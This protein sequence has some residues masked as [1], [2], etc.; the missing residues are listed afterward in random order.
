MASG[1][2]LSAGVRQNLLSL[3]NTATLSSL[4]QGRLATGKKV[5]S[6]LD[7]PTNF[8]TSQSLQDRAGDL[9]NLLD[10]IGQATQTLQQ[11]SNG[12]S[13][14]TTL[15]QSAK[16]IAKQASQ[17]SASVTNYAAVNNNANVAAA[18][19]LNGDESV[20]SLTGDSGVA[21]G[22]FGAQ[23]I[24]LSF[25]GQAEQLGQASGAAIAAP[26]AGGVAYSFDLT[27]GGVTHTVSYTSLAADAATN[28]VAGLSASIT[29][30][31]GAGPAATVALTNNAGALRLTATNADVDFTI[32]AANANSGLSNGAFNST[33]LLDNVVAGGGTAGASTL[34]ID[35]NGGTG[36]GGTTKTITFGTGAGQISTLADLKNE[37]NV[38]GVGGGASGDVTVGAFAGTPPVNTGTI[39]LGLAAGETNTLK[40]TTS[41][42][43]V[44]TAAGLGAARNIGQTGGIGNTAT[45]LS[46]TFNSAATLADSDPSTL[47]NGGN[48][49]ITV[50]GSAQTVGVSGTDRLS[51]VI[52]KLKANATLNNNLD[53]SVS[54]GNLKIASKTADVDFQVTAGAVAGGVGTAGLGLATTAQNS[55]SLLDLLGSK[56]SGGP[57]AAQGSTLTLAVNGGATQTITFG[58]NS[59]EISTKAELSTALSNLSGVTGTLANT[60][61]N[62]QVTAG[63]SA[64][65]LTTGGTA[66]AALGLTVGTQDGVA[67]P[68][69]SSTVR[70][71]YQTQ[72]NDVLTQIDSLSKDAS[73]NGINLLAGDD[74]KVTFNERGTSSLTIKGVTLD[75]NGLGLSTA[76]GTSF[77]D[78][79]QLDTTIS[80]LDNALTTLRSQASKFGSSLTTVQT[81]QDFTKNVINT[82]QTGSDSLVL[83]DTNEE[84]ANLL[85]LQTRQQLS[86]TALSLSA[87][88]ANA[89][90]RLF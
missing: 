59:G 9:N 55:T 83:A 74:L 53:F 51:D 7:N 17:A 41:D 38:V 68:G 77:Q 33:S 30:Q 61:L 66:A 16:S 56:L 47:L 73:Y 21:G 63:T 49:T 10:S 72:Y 89:V 26:G 69:A 22:D 35:V 3:Q 65:S 60:S 34:S 76:V 79:S 44:R 19:N 52:T 48:L 88:A 8:F 31:F 37:L 18:T 2:T 57:A 85:A 24:S 42:V 54:S 87:Q 43:G 80:S 81:R 75:S 86:T 64:T 50:N 28:V 25:T 4:T 6:A 11:A 40:L 62:L 82:L 20:A 45:D 23:A 14:L 84:G 39:T 58:T 70:S 78:N 90:L 32:A 15:V 5:N 46:R 1:I 12:L 36:G 29:A 27:L 67:T 13:S 71:N